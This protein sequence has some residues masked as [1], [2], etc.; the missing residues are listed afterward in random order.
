M[1][2]KFSTSL[3]S[4]FV[5]FARGDAWEE[6]QKRGGEVYS[7]LRSE[8][9]VGE[10]ATVGRYGFPFKVES[11]W[12]ASKPII[13]PLMADGRDPELVLAGYQVEPGG[14]GLPAVFAFSVA[15]HTGEALLALCDALPFDSVD[16]ARTF[17]VDC[18]Q[19]EKVSML[20]TALGGSVASKAFALCALPSSAE[21]LV[22]RPNPTR[23]DIT[24]AVTE[25][26]DA[27]ER[28]ARVISKW[29][30]TH[31]LSYLE[32]E[33]VGDKSRRLFHPRLLADL[34]QLPL[35]LKMYSSTMGEQPKRAGRPVDAGR[36]QL[37]AV[38]IAALW[39]R[40]GLGKVS[41][42]PSSRFMRACSFLLP[43]Y[44][45]PKS[46]YS[47]FMRAELRK[48]REKGVVIGA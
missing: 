13:A 25:L 18:L 33:R 9:R 42:T 43:E 3:S 22:S 31:A 41:F 14:L 6:V 35:D 24:M 45:I 46:D 29:Q 17:F 5:G 1:S 37:V 8:G 27:S 39:R 19:Q 7:R 21:H 4:D 30:D 28:L 40:C 44:G 38:V 12:R 16:R 2:L 11:N 23:R 15:F 26:T 48:R 32:A 36:D 34:Q 10:A 47:Q 20:S